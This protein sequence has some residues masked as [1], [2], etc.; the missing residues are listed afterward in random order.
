MIESQNHRMTWVPEDLKD[1]I[2]SPALSSITILYTKLLL[3]PFNVSIMNI[4]KD[5]AFT[6]SPGDP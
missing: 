1:P 4:S 2:N 6:A 3:T 5:E